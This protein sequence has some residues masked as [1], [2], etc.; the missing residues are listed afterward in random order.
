MKVSKA[1]AFK[2][3]SGFILSFLIMVMSGKVRANSTEIT[4]DVN[5]VMSDISHN[6]IGISINFTPVTTQIATS[7]KD[8]NIGSLRYPEGE[9][10]DY[11]IFDK[12]EPTKLKLSLQDSNIWSTTVDSLVKADGTYNATLSFDDFMS[13]CKSTKTEPFIIVGIDAIAYTGDAPHATPEEVLEAAVEW[14]KYANIN[15]K[16]GIKY[17]EIGN[18]TDLNIEN[19][20]YK[21]WT[22]QKYADT[23]VEFSR[24]MKAVDPS[25]EI[26]A[27]AF[28]ESKWWDK[29]L[30]IIKDDVD[31]LVPHQYSWLKSYQEWKNDPYQYDYNIKAASSAIDTYNPNLRMNVTEISS[32]NPENDSE[33]NNTWKMLHNFEVLGNALLYDRLDYLHF[34]T[35][36]WLEEDSYSESYSAFNSDY[37]LMPMGYPVK[38]W[39]NFLKRKMVYST[40]QTG[41][42]RSWASYDPDDG[43]LNVFL[44]NKDE[45]SQNINLALDNYRGTQNEGWVLKGSGPEST[46]VNWEKYNSA[47]A[48]GTSLKTTLEPLSVTIIAFE[49]DRPN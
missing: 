16:Y 27:N 20:G 4:V 7:L 43:S 29:I 35:A 45:V 40:R 15:K 1:T 8:L 26:G 17:W 48:D 31:F 5:Q 30:P 19:D 21:N 47:S 38:I 32:L 25:I 2:F 10:G 36:K 39:S 3:L 42:I 24:A 11:Y 23:V 18:E 12:D 22:A 6:P 34:W 44:L 33:R 46:D 14:V 13:I 9:V 37:K 41:T 49:S 28:A